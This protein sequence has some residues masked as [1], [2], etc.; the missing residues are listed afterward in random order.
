MPFKSKRQQRFMF[1]AEER[2]DVPKGTA[3]RWA[4]ET[5]NIKKLPEKVRKKKADFEKQARELGEKVAQWWMHALRYGGPAA[6]G[7][8][9]AGPGYRMEGA[10]GGALAGH[11][12]GK[13]LG[14]YGYLRSQPGVA[15]AIKGGVPWQQAAESIRAGRAIG[16][17]APA[18]TSQMQQALS[19]A[20][21]AG[22]LGMGALG[23]YTAGR[24]MGLQNPYG[25]QPVFPGAMQEN[26]MGLRPE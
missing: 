22:R 2:N 18:V 11:F 5:P 6:A 4:R 15:K 26:P 21:L 24:L 25:L 20:G 3:K 9:L 7:A 16:G 23:G 14:E 13:G 17:S 10:L 1:A 19:R 12:L 8:Y